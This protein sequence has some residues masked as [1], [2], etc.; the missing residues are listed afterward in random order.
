MPTAAK[1]LLFGTVIGI[2]GITASLLP[3]VL[4][5]EAHLGLKLLFWLRGPRPA[6]PEV[7]MVTIDRESA[8]HFRIRNEPA[9][10]PRA[11]HAQVV[12]E[13]SVRG[14]G[15]IVL[16][17]AFERP[18]GPKHDPMLAQA[19]HQAGNVVLFQRRDPGY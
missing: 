7:A 2:V 19:L 16:D 9:L 8:D 3:A 1:A 14:A 11:L 15:V 17:I 10:W 6:P 5:V 4:D 12:Q 18:Q 13:L